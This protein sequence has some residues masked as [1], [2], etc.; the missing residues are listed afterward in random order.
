MNRLAKMHISL[1]LIRSLLALP[2]DVR[3]LRIRMSDQINSAG[4]S[5]ECIIES[6][7]IP[8]IADGAMIPVATPS[9][10]TVYGDRPSRSVFNGWGLP[11]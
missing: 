3:F 5:L 11:S 7:T 10:T 2:D 6:E 9:I 4:G 1:E 8:E